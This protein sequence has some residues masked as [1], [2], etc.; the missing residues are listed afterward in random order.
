MSVPDQSQQRI[1]KIMIYLA[2]VL[3]IGV[4][5]WLFDGVLER[6]DNPN[7]DLRTETGGS[8]M[9]EVVLQRSRSGHYV[10]PG[11]IN[12]YPVLFLLDTGATT[13]SIPASVAENIHLPRGPKQLT[14]TANG[15]IEVI[16][17]VADEIALGPLVLQDVSANINPYMH[18]DEVLLG[19]SFMR[20]MELIQR[21]DQLTIRQY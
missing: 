10:A 9:R 14:R 16:S 17:T 12:G 4:L 18:G 20:H 13:V 6:W 15:V 19:M 8:G 7:R 11:T 5:T 1:G 3:A 21:G 2:W